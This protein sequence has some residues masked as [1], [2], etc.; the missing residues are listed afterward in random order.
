[1]DLITFDELPGSGSA[2]PAD[3][4]GLVWGNMNF[5]N[6]VDHNNASGYYAGM[7]SR[8]NVAYNGY[9]TNASLG[10][11]SPFG[12]LSAYLTAAWNDNLQVQVLGYSVGTLLYSNNY[13]LSATTP[14]LINFGYNGVTEVDFISSG[15][16]QHPGYLG[17]GKHFVM[18]NVNILA[19][20]TAPT[21]IAQ[22]ASPGSERAC[23]LP[24]PL[25]PATPPTTCSCP[26]PGPGSIA[27]L[28]TLTARPPAPT[29]C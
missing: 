28:A 13:I 19:T 17:N 24:A 15:G 10:Q 5:L 16:T 12:L 18:D 3:Y 14:T 20:P 9:G 29:P 22:P 2:V 7:I 6:A 11:A 8:S 27:W 1:V 23:P 25:L 21:V 26:I 4:H